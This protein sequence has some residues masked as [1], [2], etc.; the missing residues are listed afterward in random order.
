MYTN[1]NGDQGQTPI[2]TPATPVRENSH[3]TPLGA[4]IGRFLLTKC[5]LTF[6]NKLYIT[7]IFLMVVE[8]H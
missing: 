1:K 4:A 5:Q 2:E 6:L 3:L 7:E 8:K